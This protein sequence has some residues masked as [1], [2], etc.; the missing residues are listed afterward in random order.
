MSDQGEPLS[1]RKTLQEQ[2]LDV[3][4][5]HGATVA[6]GLTE[7][8]VAIRSQDVRVDAATAPEVRALDI[9]PGSLRVPKGSPAHRNSIS[10]DGGYKLVLI[11]RHS[12]NLKALPSLRVQE[13]ELVIGKGNKVLKDRYGVERELSERELARILASAEDVVQI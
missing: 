13:A 12:I 8:G 3:F 2:L 5:R 11:A 10:H 1:W 4:D 7:T 6:V 9:E